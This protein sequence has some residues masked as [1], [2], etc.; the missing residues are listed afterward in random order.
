MSLLL[1]NVVSFCSYCRKAGF[2]VGFQETMEAVELVN[3]GFI[4]NKNQFKFALRSVLCS[5]KDEFEY[6]DALFESYWKNRAMGSYSLTQ[7]GGED[8]TTIKRQDTQSTTYIQSTILEDEEEE[9][10]DSEFTSSKVERLKKTDFTKITE[11]D[12][13]IYNILAQRFYAQMMTRI[14]RKNKKLNHKSRLDLRRTIR[15]NL[16]YGGYPINLEFKS[17]IKQK[18]DL[19]IFSDVSGSMDLYSFHFLKFVIHLHKYFRRIY[20]FIFSTRLLDITELL[21]QGDLKKIIRLLQE[22]ANM[23]SSGT[24]MGECLYQFNHTH[25]NRILAKRPVVMFFSDG[26]ET[27]SSELLVNEIKSIKNR[28]KKILWINPLK[29]MKDYEPIT[30]AMSE[31]VPLL[32]EFRPGHNMESLLDLE[33]CLNDIL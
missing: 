9:G 5:S 19:L 3:L 2:R 26:L 28:S 4:H 29:G 25:A 15:E 30:K 23:W 7:Q 8:K 13:P 18:R 20:T 14:S 12:A 10:E 21:N 1:Q 6:F 16:K 32:D 17:R 11:I 31:I 24:T 27:G 33:R 22:Q